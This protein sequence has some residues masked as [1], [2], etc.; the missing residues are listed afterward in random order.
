M[1][2]VFSPSEN[3]FSTNLLWEQPYCYIISVYSAFSDW[4][5]QNVTKIQKWVL[6][7]DVVILH[8]MMSFRSR[9]CEKWCQSDTLTWEDGVNGI[10]CASKVLVLDAIVQ[11]WSNA[12]WN[13]EV[14][15]IHT[16]VKTILVS[17]F[18]Y[19]GVTYMYPIWNVCDLNVCINGV[20]SRWQKGETVMNGYYE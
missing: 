4:W 1:I 3:I 20:S 18:E 7:P 8:L 2:N 5:E 14:S 13:I 19:M 11:R 9:V 16:D 17:P 10:M 12:L 6:S 15:N